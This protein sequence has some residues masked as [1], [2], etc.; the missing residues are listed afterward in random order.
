MAD[1]TAG[2]SIH[3]LWPRTQWATLWVS[4]GFQ[5]NAQLAL[6]CLIR[7]QKSLSTL[8]HSN[9]EPVNKAGCLRGFVPFS[10]SFH[11]CCDKN[12]PQL[13]R[14]GSGVPTVASFSFLSVQCFNS[15]PLL[16]GLSNIFMSGQTPLTLLICFTHRPAANGFD[17][18]QWMEKHHIYGRFRDAAT[19]TPDTNSR[20]EE[21]RFCPAYSNMESKCNW[22]FVCFVE[23]QPL[24]MMD[25]LEVQK[26]NLSSERGCC[27]LKNELGCWMPE[28]TEKYT[29]G[30]KNEP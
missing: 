1:C 9:H 24:V 12:C 19:T 18:P 4:C 11:I 5:V 29:I 26:I 22:T 20:T 30:K 23:L 8:L 16:F 28:S 14:Y 3:L 17:A 27:L 6:R 21:I 7:A 25:I 13:S 2:R 10:I 15:T